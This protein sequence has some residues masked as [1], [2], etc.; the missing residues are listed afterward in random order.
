MEGMMLH[1]DASSHEWVPGRIWD[2]IVTLDDA[3]SEM[4]CRAPVTDTT[5]PKARPKP[6]QSSSIQPGVSLHRVQLVLL[7][8]LSRTA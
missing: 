7:R 6:E 3:T 4:S 8:P 5:A 2:L 1:Q